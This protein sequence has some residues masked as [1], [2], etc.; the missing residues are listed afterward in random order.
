MFK[1]WFVDFD[2]VRAK[3]S[4]K[5]NGQDPTRAAMAAIAAI[6]VE[7]LDTLPPEQLK[8]LSSTATLL[9]DTLVNSELGE[10]PEG[11]EVKALSKM[12]ELIGGGTPK[13]SEEAFWNGE[14]PWFSVK[15]APADGDV[16]VVDTDAKITELGLNK[17]STKL[18]P[19]GVTIISA[20]GTVGRLALV[21]VPTAMNQSCYG[22]KGANDVGPYLNYYNLK[23]AVLTLQQN[24]HGAVFDTITRGTFDTV[25]R[26]DPSEDL[27]RAY[28]TLVTPL[29][30]QIKNNLF[31][32]K[33]LE[34]L[35]DALLPKLLSG[36]IDMSEVA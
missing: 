22:V 33:S 24:T 2:P 36:E 17:S 9:P 30:L 4:A 8:T 34:Q 12:V 13:K 32:T 25:F 18:L 15:D 6:T 16:F 31:E 29:F 7:Q 26:V 5:E 20:R 28:E 11:W 14:I 21:G 19:E 3:I 10:I 1:S 35:R 23:E 27:K